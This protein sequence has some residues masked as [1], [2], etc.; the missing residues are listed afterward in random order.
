MHNPESNSIVILHRSICCSGYAAEI[1][2][3]YWPESLLRE[4]TGFGCPTMRPE[5]SGFHDQ[6][7]DAS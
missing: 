3:Q 6:K 4:S 5:D 1:C 7:L 2:T